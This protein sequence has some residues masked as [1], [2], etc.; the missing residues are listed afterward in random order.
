MKEYL[1]GIFLKEKK[2]DNGSV[3]NATITET[4]LNDAKSKMQDG[5]L[6]VRIQE[7]KEAD[8]Y[9]NTHY[10]TVDDWKPKEKVDPIP[11]N[12]DIPF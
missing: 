5:K 11:D 7:R 8:K 2:F 1:N 10:V 12:S 9:G 3:I 4:F 6:R